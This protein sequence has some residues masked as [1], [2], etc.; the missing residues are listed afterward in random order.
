VAVPPVLM[1]GNHAEIEKWRR[2]R[3]GSDRAQAPDLLVKARAAGL[4]TRKDEQ[5]LAGL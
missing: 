5:F 3:A 4:L 1:G 2:Q